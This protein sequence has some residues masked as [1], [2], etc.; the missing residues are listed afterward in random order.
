M[1]ARV[2]I[3]TKRGSHLSLHFV[4]LG[5]SEVC[6]I[7]SHPSFLSHTANHTL[8]NMCRGIDQKL[9]ITLRRHRCTDESRVYIPEPIDFPY[10]TSFPSS[11]PCQPFT[12]HVGITISMC[13]ACEYSRFP[14]LELLM[15]DDLVIVTVTMFQ[16]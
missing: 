9:D 15:A 13:A 7:C 12:E 10:S 6:A 8:Q 4:G 16:T 3:Y 2:A 1:A 14:I 5:G 11:P